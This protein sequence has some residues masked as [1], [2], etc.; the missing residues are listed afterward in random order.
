MARHTNKTPAWLVGL[1]L[2]VVIFAAVALLLNLLG[3]GDDPV[4]EGLSGLYG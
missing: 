1:I 2:A 3:Y 4:V